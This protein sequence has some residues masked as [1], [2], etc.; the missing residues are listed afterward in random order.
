MK[1]SGTTSGQLAVTAVIAVTHGDLIPR[2]LRSCSEVVNVLTTYA[3]ETSVA[4]SSD[5]LPPVV[6]LVARTVS[7]PE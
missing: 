1:P 7:S 6:H 3:P 2:A 4:V 5:G